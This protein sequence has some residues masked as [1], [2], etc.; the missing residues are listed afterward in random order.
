M[1]HQSTP[2]EL[3]LAADLDTEAQRFINMWICNWH[4]LNI[5]GLATDVD[6]FRGGRIRLGGVLF[7]G[8]VQQ[9]YWEAIGRYLRGY[10]HQTMKSWDAS[11]VSYP[12]PQRRSSLDSTEGQLISFSSRVVSKATVTDRRLRGRGFP[13]NAPAYNSSKT[14]VEAKVEIA[15]LAEAHR[16]LLGSDIRVSHNLNEP[17]MQYDVFISHASEDKSTLV[18]DLVYK[19]RARKVEVWYD[20]GSL[21]WGR[22]LRQQIDEGLVNSRFGVVVL[23]PSFLRKPWPKAE[24]DGLLSMDMRGTSRILPI[25]HQLSYEQVLEVSPLMATRFARETAKSSVDELVEEIVELCRKH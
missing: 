16:S 11:T 14:L 8:Q 7:E 10:V 12:Y 1:L 23:S 18:N 15:R 2:F 13:D 4:N 9:I 19:L 21:E 5:Q 22:S 3:G 25:W 17:G 20:A 6:D 24:L